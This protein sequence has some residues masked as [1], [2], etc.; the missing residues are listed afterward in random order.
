[1]GC[2]ASTNQVERPVP[3]R[4]LTTTSSNIKDKYNIHAKVLGEGT[5]GKV[6]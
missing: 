3:Q 2:T 5:Y 1:M 4:L 6:Y